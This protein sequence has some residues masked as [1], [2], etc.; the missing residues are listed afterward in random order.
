MKTGL[1]ILMLLSIAI[2]TAGCASVVV[3]YN[4]TPLCSKG[5]TGG[6]CASL[7]DVYDE[8]NKEIKESGAYAGS[9]KNARK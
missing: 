5:I 3:P 9:R 8:V 1:F 2:L 4:E 6:Y 7:T